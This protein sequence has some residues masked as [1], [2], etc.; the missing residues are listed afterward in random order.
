M[1]VEMIGAIAIAAETVV[2][3]LFNKNYKKKGSKNHQFIQRAEKKGCVVQ[4]TAVSSE[5]RGGIYGH[6]SP[7]MRADARIVKYEYRV[8][9]RV[10]YKKMTFQSPG[11]THVSYPDTV[12]VYYDA[13]NPAK[14][15]CRE[16]A[17]KAQQIRSGGL[18]TIGVFILTL[19]VVI[20]I[21]KI[22]LG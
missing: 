17:T 2:S 5:F 11:M 15:V 3:V 18:A 22:F 13:S 1:S 9:G 8:D 19:F 21:L 7:Y 12:K 10:Y 20:N 4:G 6:S 14:A 16:E